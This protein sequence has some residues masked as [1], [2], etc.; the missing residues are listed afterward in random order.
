VPWEFKRENFVFHTRTCLWGTLSLVFLIAA[1]AHA[2]PPVIF[3]TGVDS[4][5]AVLPDGT[6]DPHYIVGPGTTVL[7]NSALSP[8]PPADTLS[9]WIMP[10]TNFG[11]GSYLY[12]TTFVE[13]TP[14][15][16]TVNGQWAAYVTGLDISLNGVSSGDTTPNPGFTNWTPFSI[17]GTAIAGTN[18]LDF[19][20]SEDPRFSP[21]TGIRV[22]IS[23]VTPEPAGLALLGLGGFG[24]LS[25]R[26]AAR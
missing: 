7:V 3:N 12:S 15:S 6:V 24:L 20:A 22:E 10:A 5:G 23:S 14:G 4:T 18:T 1:N 25:R 19:R 9:A 17:T 21:N 26:R 13:S 8:T 16:I 2:A 11:A